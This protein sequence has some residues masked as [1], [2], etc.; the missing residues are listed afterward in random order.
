MRPLLKRT[1]LWALQVAEDAPV[2][3]S[4]ALRIS[5]VIND[6]DHLWPRRALACEWCSSHAGN[7]SI[8]PLADVALWHMSYAADHNI[9]ALSTACCSSA[10]VHGNVPSASQEPGGNPA[11]LAL[12][13]ETLL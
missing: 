5:I 3:A 1:R 10:S 4:R 11:A 7:L 8:L 2:A 6:D 9:L 13:Q 12:L